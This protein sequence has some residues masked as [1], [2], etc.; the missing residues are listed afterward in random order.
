MYSK[1]QLGIKYLGYYFSASNGKGHGMHSPFVFEFITRVLNDH[2]IYP[3]YYEVEKLRNHLLQDQSEI[4]IED[5]GAGSVT[6]KSNS[7]TVASV[8]RNAAKPA[9]YGQLLFRIIKYYQPQNILEL[10][11]SLGITTSYLSLANSSAKLVTLEGASAIVEKARLNL[12]TL[13]ISNVEIIKG[14][15][16][17]TLPVVI[18]AINETKEKPFVDFVFVDGNHRY[19]PTVKYFNQLLSARNNESIFIFDD[20]HW[21]REMEQAWEFIRTH[22]DVKCSVDLFFIGIIFFRREFKEKQHFCIRF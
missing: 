13:D 14:Q 7:R 8:A 9:K 21:S 12:N 1:F 19:E 22:P 6:N 2:T 10:G 4:T 16:D 15:F 20:I 3:A 18:E 5:W 11:T 17:E